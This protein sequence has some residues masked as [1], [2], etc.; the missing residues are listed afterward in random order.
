MCSAENYSYY[1]Q[2]NMRDQVHGVIEDAH[3]E[4]SCRLLLNMVKVCYCRR[5]A[6]VRFQHFPHCLKMVSV[7]SQYHLLVP[8]Y[9]ERPKS[10]ETGA[11]CNILLCIIMVQLT[12]RQRKEISV[13]Q[14]IWRTFCQ[15]DLRLFANRLIV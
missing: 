5:R 1:E 6:K 7:L 4:I 13:V 15:E 3:Q 14:N 9:P 12:F 2:T 8:S 10:L 11:P